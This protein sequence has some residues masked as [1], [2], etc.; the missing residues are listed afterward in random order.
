MRILPLAAT[1]AQSCDNLQI[2]AGEV[3]EDYF[4]QHCSLSS[5]LQRLVA[6][7]AQEQQQQE[8]EQQGLAALSD[9]SSA[10]LDQ[11][12]LQGLL[13]DWGTARL[14]LQGK[15]Q[16]DD[17]LGAEQQ[18]QLVQLQQAWLATVSRHC[19][20]GEHTATHSKNRVGK[21]VNAQQLYWVV[22]RSMHKRGHALLGQHC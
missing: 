3:D 11:Q 8:Q 18:E 5:Q 14:V 1:A 4:Q 16:Q 9:C 22:H 2:L 19:G 12:Q 20:R 17:E 6:T 7:A 21:Y 13:Q 15:L 10:V